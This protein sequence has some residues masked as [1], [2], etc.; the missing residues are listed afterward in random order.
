MR[1]RRRRF[2]A[3]NELVICTVKKITPYAAFCI[4]D[5]FEN[6]EGMLH[7][8]EISSRI[9]RNVREKLSEGQ[10]IICKVI[11]VN[12]GKGFIDLSI[13]RVAEFERR[14]KRDEIK[15][16][17][18]AHKII[19][20][21]CKKRGIDIDEFF[22]KHFRKMYEEGY[23]YELFER[24]VEEGKKVLK[25]CL[26][27]DFLED[28][29]KTIEKEFGKPFRE[30]RINLELI[31]YDSD[32]IL[33]VRKFFS[34]MKEILGKVSGEVNII[35]LGAPKYLVILKTKD[36]KKAEKRLESL[37]RELEDLARSLKIEFKYEREKR[38]RR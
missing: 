36:P 11:R 2:P 7:I 27:Q 33:K 23:V 31:S 17:K 32:G 4:L 20:L 6:K 22:E 13:K 8:T 35:Y 16:E 1:F 14:R 28:F 25:K 18:R 21:F 15:K 26:S 3:L 12:P 30:I 5:E 9:I 10:K 37:M 29:L 34:F 19:E 24:A 38:W